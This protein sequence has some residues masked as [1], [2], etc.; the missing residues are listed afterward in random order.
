MAFW[1]DINASPKLSYRWTLTIGEIASYTLRSF[2]KPSFEI[3][4]SEYI[5]IN[6]PAYKPG[7]L[8]WSPIEVALID[9]E[10]SASN[11]TSILYKI[12]EECGYLKAPNGEPMSA[13]V[14]SNAVNA[15]GG[16]VT[17]DQINADNVSIEQWKLIN[18][19]ITQINFGQANYGADEMMTIAM[20]LRYDYAVYESLL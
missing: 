19:F 10:D 17:F 1:S 12:I 16:Q 3:A 20:T 2:Q 4:V 18:P 9:G 11:N 14:K 8:T 6:D 5:N 15:L 13:I 7:L